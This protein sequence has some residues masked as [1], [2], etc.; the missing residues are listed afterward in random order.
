VKLFARFQE[1]L[2]GK[3][4]HLLT[5]ENTRAVADVEQAILDAGTLSRKINAWEFRWPLNTYARDLGIEGLSPVMRARLE[6]AE[7]MTL[8]AYQKL[9]LD[10]ARC[11]D[12][13]AQTA[14]VADAY[15]TLS[16]PG[17]APIGLASTGDPTFAIPGSLLGVPAISMPVFEIDGLPLGLQV[18]GFNECDANLF[19]VAAWL[20]ADH[21]AKAM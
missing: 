2:A 6:E 21:L 3:G 5:R 8:E 11:R 16:A 10:R 4:V 20:Q 17:P 19:S 1:T 18:L 12:V 7:S 15:I 14:S 9:L 13:Y